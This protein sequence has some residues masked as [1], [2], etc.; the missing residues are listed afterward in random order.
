[1]LKLKM[2]DGTWEERPHRVKRLVD[3]YFISLFTFTGSREWGTILE[4]VCFLVTN[5]MNKSLL[6]P[7]TDEE[8]QEVEMQ[9]GSLQAQGLD[10]FQGIFYH[11]FWETLKT[12]VSALIRLLKSSEVLF[13]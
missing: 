5:S 6:A 3:D 2:E 12:E 13:S 9:I 11:S 1:M 8:I 4:Y 10:G 7:I